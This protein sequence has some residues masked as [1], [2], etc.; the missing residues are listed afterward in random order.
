MANSLYGLPAEQVEGKITQCPGG[1]Y[2]QQNGYSYYVPEDVSDATSAFIYYP[3]SGGAGNDAAVLRQIINEGNPN[4]I[5]II[6]NTAYE[7]IDVASERYFNLIE[8]IGNENGATISNIATMGF[9]AGGPNTFNGLVNNVM[10]HPDA[11]PQSAVF[12]DVVGFNVSDEAISALK[13]NNS[14]LMFLEPMNTVTDFEKRLA[15]N[16]VNVILAWTGNGHNAHTTLNKEAFQ[17]GIVDLTSADIEELANNGIY[18]F[19]SYNPDTGKWEPISMEDVAASFAEGVATTNDPFRYYKK[20]GNL[21]ELQCNNDFIASKVNILR[22]AIKNTNFLTTM[23]TDS[24]SSTTNIPNGEAEIIQNYFST[25]A[26][27]LNLLEKDTVKIVQIGNS[28][29][30]INQNLKN[31]ADNLNN[32]VSYYSGG[33]YSGY[34][35]GYTSYG[36][37]TGGTVASI[38]SSI[39]STEDSL[40]TKEKL[41]KIEKIKKDF[42]DYDELYSDDEKYVYDK[43]GEYKIV[44]HYDEDEILALEYYFDYK[45]EDAAKEAMEEIKKKFEGVEDVVNK[46]QYVKV[47]FDEDV[48]KGLSLEGLKKMYE[49]LKEIV[50]EEK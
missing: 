9:S 50:K 27:L 23:G 17:N 45:T 44:I 19:V 26:S 16:G 12:V 30:D 15:A 8:N 3:G 32:S 21:E 10:T 34:S 13:N 1:V 6:A 40:E 7:K 29:A 31:E 4:Q 39:L 20:L 47:I 11:G 42:I 48:Y 2:I 49:D 33:N 41:E 38:G 24:Y 37:V 5:I 43:N 35:G 22:N 18:T 46:G 25:C 14:T 36:G 28:I